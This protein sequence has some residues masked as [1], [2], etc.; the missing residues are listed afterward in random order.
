[1]RTVVTVVGL[2]IVAGLAIWQ[3]TPLLPDLA[4]GTRLVLEPDL[5]SVPASERAAILNETTEVLRR[6][7]ASASW[8]WSGVETT[9]DGRISVRLVGIDDL[10]SAK[11]LLTRPAKLEFREKNVAGGREAWV[12][13]TAIGSGGV[14]TALSGRFLK[15]AEVGFDRTQKPVILFEFNEE[16]TRLFADIT[17]RL[18]GTAA[19]RELGIFLDDEP[20]STPRVQ[21][22]ITGGK[23]QITGSFTADEAKNLVHQLN[24][25]WLPVP[26]RVVSVHTSPAGDLLESLRAR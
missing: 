11:H 10:D 23:G 8:V 2:L 25:G 16:G 9:D 22:R 14:E 1:M 24:S 12:P 3:F 21:E 7:V 26:V 4:P 19:K 20:L 15:K 18:G 6:R 13:A 17:Q 5:S